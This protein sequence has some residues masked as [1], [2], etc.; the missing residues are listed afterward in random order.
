[1]LCYSAVVVGLGDTYTNS[2]IELDVGF[3]G[4]FD[5]CNWN[6]IYRSIKVYF[7]QNYIAKTQ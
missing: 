5:Y 7:R 1:M 4:E 2:E 3:V 6:V